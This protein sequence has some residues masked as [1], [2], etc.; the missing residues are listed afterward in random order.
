MALSIKPYIEN[1]ETIHLIGIGGVSMNSL[2]ELLMSKGVPVIRPDRLGTCLL[3]TYYAADARSRFD[4]VGCR[5]D[6]TEE[7]YS[8]II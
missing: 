8:I 2:A 5:S 6:A 4:R 3:Y 1:K 7:R